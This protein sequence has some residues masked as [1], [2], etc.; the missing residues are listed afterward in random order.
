MIDMNCL[1]Y[2]LGNAFR[3]VV[4]LTAGALML[5]ALPAGAGWLDRGIGVA[6]AGKSVKETLDENTGILGKMFD[7]V[8]D[9][10]EEAL[11]GLM[12]EV[13]KTPGKLIKRTFPAL[14]APQAVA[15][16][17]KSA[18]Q[19]IERFAGGVR[20]GLADARAALATDGEDRNGGWSD[21]SLLKDPL[22]APPDTA[23]AA[24]G[25]APRPASPA[26]LA[27]KP[28]QGAGSADNPADP[29]W[30]FEQWVIAKQEAHPHCYGVVDP[31]TL[32]PECFGEAGAAS[33]AAGK[34]ADSPRAAGDWTVEDDGWSGWDKSD[35]RYSDADREAA[36]VGVFAVR[37]WGVY[38]VTKRHGLY[39]LMRERMQRNECPN[40][41][42]GRASYDDATVPGDG[43]YLSALSDLEAQEAERLR[44]EKEERQRQARLE[45]EERERQAQLEAEEERERQAQLAQQREFN[46]Q[47][48]Q[49]LGQA[50][51]G[52]I[53]AYSG[54]GTY[55]GGGTTGGNAPPTDTGCPDGPEPRSVGPGDTPGCR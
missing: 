45:A 25:L 37:C 38:E 30:D 12:E 21:A 1:R 42:T 43:D 44:L 48:A 8:M 16:R 54:D 10:D 46:R 33:P 20:E 17:L 5:C 23:F 51:G 53:R 49:Q 18:K 31:E 29:A 7:A 19:K 6:G 14:E 41:E 9:D 32:P 34:V 50:L 4:T 3:P 27:G 47:A 40:E 2:R 26:A 55:G 36:R 35:P 28:G 39:E 52:L 11:S 24:S 15:D 22:P 13:A